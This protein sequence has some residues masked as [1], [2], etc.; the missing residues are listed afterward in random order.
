[1]TVSPLLTVM[2]EGAYEAGTEYGFPVTPLLVRRQ[3]YYSYL[4]GGF[5]TYGHNDSWRILPTWRASL[6][7]PG[8][9]AFTLRTDP[10]TTMAANI[11]KACTEPSS[12]RVRMMLS[13]AISR[14]K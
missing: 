13:P 7:A 2:D 3:A 5:H 6:D 10:R 4:S 12:S 9:L 14:R 8:E 1:M 11:E